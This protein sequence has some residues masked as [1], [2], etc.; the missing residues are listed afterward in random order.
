MNRK[1]R[2]RARRAL[3]FGYGRLMQFR[4]R[5]STLLTEEVNGFLGDRTA[6]QL[7]SFFIRMWTVRI[8]TLSRI[9][10]LSKHQTDRPVR[11]YLPKLIT[12]RQSPDKYWIRR[13]LLGR[14][15]PYV[16]HI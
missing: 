15:S 3:L 2:K 5:G 9:L 16:T 7:D 11:I 12:R 1:R 6:F 14:T 8:K 13:Q 4:L 10:E